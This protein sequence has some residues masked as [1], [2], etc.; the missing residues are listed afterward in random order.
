MTFHLDMVKL[1]SCF[2][3]W[4]SIE[5]LLGGGEEHEQDEQRQV[6]RDA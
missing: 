1:P 5:H 3:F 2:S 4:H 6:R